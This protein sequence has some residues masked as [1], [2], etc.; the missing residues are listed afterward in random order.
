MFTRPLA[1]VGFVGL[2]SAASVS[3]QLPADDPVA[4][5][6]EIEKLAGEWLPIA[7]VHCGKEL[8]KEELAKINFSAGKGGYGIDLSPVIPAG[9]WPKSYLLHL[10]AKSK[11]LSFSRND[12]IKEIGYYGIYEVKEDKLRIGFALTP[13]ERTSGDPSYAMNPPRDFATEPPA[14]PSMVSTVITFKRI[15][16]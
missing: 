16:K 8:N 3:A 2:F 6:A 12:G 15:K 7:A 9:G 13:W 10:N 1:L 4:W 5:A 11:Q 14:R